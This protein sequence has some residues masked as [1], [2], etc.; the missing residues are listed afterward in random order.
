MIDL[1]RLRRAVHLDA[2]RVGGGWLVDGRMVDLEHGCGCPDRLYRD[3]TCKHEI[4]ARLDVLGPDL[5]EALRLL[6][7]VA[8]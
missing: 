1:A 8:S 6:G 5:R 3:A 2:K 4:A 7:E